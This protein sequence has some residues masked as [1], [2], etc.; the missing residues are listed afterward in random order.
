MGKNKHKDIRLTNRMDLSGID[1]EPLDKPY[2]DDISKM[3]VL[4][5]KSMKRKGTVVWFNKTTGYGFIK[6]DEDGKDYF[7]H[8]KGILGK[9]FKKLETDQRVEFDL[10]QL[11]DRPICIEVEIVNE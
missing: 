6:D 11:N 5:K 8:W 9:G 4:E 1:I 7:V 10:E 3:I 2:I